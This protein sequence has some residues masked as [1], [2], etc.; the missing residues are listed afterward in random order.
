VSLHEQPLF[1]VSRIETPEQLEIDLPLAGVGTRGLAYALDL[2]VQLVPL[3]FLAI[4]AYVLLP[5]ESRPSELFVEGPRRGRGYELDRFALAFISVIVFVM[6][7]GYF[8]LFELWWRGQTPGK[9]ALGLRVLRDGGYPID[10]RAALVRNLLRMVDMLP[11][12]YLLGIVTM[13]AGRQGKRVGDYAAGTIVVLQR[14]V[15]EPSQALPPPGSTEPRSSVLTR[16]ERRLVDEFLARR[17]QLSSA[18]RAR[19][20]GALAARIAGRLGH[21]NPADPERYLERL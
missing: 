14:R 5:P 16:D 4:I 11:T 19:V 17:P 15:T 20:A 3:L 18:A 7:F 12:S 21:A 8:A 13:L 10:A 9:R 2:L 6:N 1:E